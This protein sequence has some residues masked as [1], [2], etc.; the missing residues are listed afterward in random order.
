MC[1]NPIDTIC[2]YKNITQ[3]DIRE[4]N[5]IKKKKRQKTYVLRENNQPI[6]QC[7]VKRKNTD[8]IP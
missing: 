1:K 3:T 7:Q 5:S 4:K 8:R 6:L 2:K